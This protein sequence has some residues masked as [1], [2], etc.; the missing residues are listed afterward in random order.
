MALIAAENLLSGLRGEI[1]P[2]CINPE[3][4]RT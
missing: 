1:P 2:H 3:A 4:L